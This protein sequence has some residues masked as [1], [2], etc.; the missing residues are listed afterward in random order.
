MK[1]IVNCQI[2]L[3][4]SFANIVFLTKDID[5]GHKCTRKKAGDNTLL[6]I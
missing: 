2:F 5:I 1:K 6:Y 3:L 4:F